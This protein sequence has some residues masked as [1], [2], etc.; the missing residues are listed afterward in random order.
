MLGLLTLEQKE[1]N[2]E[3]QK[4]NICKT[5]NVE[6]EHRLFP[7]QLALSDSPTLSDLGVYKLTILA[8]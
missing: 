2:G 5:T 1:E 6:A 8:F 3:N 4:G 7:R